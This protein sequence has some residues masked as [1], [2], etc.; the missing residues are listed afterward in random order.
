MFIRDP[1]TRLTAAAEYLH[2]YR[3][4]PPELLGPRVTCLYLSSLHLVELWCG[5]ADKRSFDCHGVRNA[6]VKTRHKWL[7]GL[8]RPIFD[9]GSDARYAPHELAFDADSVHHYLFQRQYRSLVLKINERTDEAYAVPTA[10]ALD[11]A[12]A[13]QT[14]AV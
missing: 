11:A 4:I 1:A 10:I 3:T 5:H 12:R 2:A 6:W 14:P 8:Y 13:A 7:H 9:A